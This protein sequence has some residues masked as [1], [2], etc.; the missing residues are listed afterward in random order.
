MHYWSKGVNE[1]VAATDGLAALTGTDN[2][3]HKIIY[4][5]YSQ[6]RRS[7]FKNVTRARS[8]PICC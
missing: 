7:D 6:C 2:S 3:A 5:S 1:T 8:H 4:V